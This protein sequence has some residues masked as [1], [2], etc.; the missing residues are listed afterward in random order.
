MSGGG[1]ISEHDF[2]VL[3]RLL[4]EGCPAQFIDRILDDLERGVKLNQ[5]LRFPLDVSER[6]QSDDGGPSGCSPSDSAQ[7]SLAG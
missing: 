6:G 2:R 4:D 1:D 3:N 5:I 7:A